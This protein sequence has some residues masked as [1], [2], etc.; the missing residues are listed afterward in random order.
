MNPGLSVIPAEAGIFVVC[1]MRPFLGEVTWA[2]ED[3]LWRRLLNEANVNLTPGSACHNGEPGFM[4]LCFAAQPT[5]AVVEAVRRVGR[6]L[7][8]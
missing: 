3:A 1:D 5:A 6:V 2:A 4:R 7:A 8:S